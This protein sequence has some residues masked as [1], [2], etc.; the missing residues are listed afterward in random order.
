MLIDDSLD[1][2]QIADIFQRVIFFENEETLRFD[3]IVLIDSNN[4]FLHLFHFG[5][6]LRMVLEELDN[7]LMVFC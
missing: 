4:H 3:Y 1:T 6:V 5:I 7:E 2:L